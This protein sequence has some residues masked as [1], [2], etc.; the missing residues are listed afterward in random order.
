MEIPASE[1]SKAEKLAY[2]QEKQDSHYFNH[3]K[4]GHDFSDTTMV[5]VVCPTGGGKSTLVR[6]VSKR[7]GVAQLQSSMTRA[8][9]PRDR[10]EP[11]HR[12]SVPLDEFYYGAI[13]ES[14]VNFFVNRN[15][16][17]YGTFPGGFTEPMTIGAIGY[18]TFEQLSQ[19]GFK[20]TPVMFPVMP[21]EVYDERLTS[22]RIYQ[23]DIVQRL[24]QGVDTMHFGK[25]HLGADWFTPILSSNAPG[26]LQRA[27]DDVYKIVRHES[28]QTLTLPQAERYMDEMLEVC[29][30]HLGRL[31]VQ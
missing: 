3:H 8:M 23:P 14:I 30:R 10:H 18:E 20:A 25:N 12:F 9:E 27:A 11:H 26:E 7:H 6:E 31:A 1:P 24:Q 16:E 28:F 21:G 29:Q 2:L 4:Y 13:D 15:N 19:A 17:V 5:C 22:G